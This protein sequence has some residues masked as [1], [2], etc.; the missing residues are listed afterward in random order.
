M[1]T[2]NISTQG[3]ITTGSGSK[4][5]DI[6]LSDGSIISDSADIDGNK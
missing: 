6:T 2:N 4:L 1:G 3:I 5:G